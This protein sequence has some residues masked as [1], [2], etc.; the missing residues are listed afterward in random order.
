MDNHDV[1]PV[2]GAADGS[3]PEP[4][5]AG[6]A[7]S[8]CLGRLRRPPWWVWS[9]L[10]VFLGAVLLVQFTEVLPDHAIANI[11]TWVLT[12]VGLV[13]LWAWFLFGSGYRRWV[14]WAT[15]PGVLAVVGVLAVLFRIDHVSGE[16]VPSF[17]L[18][19]SRKAERV[20]ETGSAVA[21]PDVTRVPVDLRTTT[22]FDFP[23]FLGPDRS[24]SARDVKLA[25]DWIARPPQA[26]W[27][28]EIGSGWSGFAVVNGH[29]VTMEQ[30]GPWETVACYSVT[31][32]E[33]EWAHS[34]GARY[35][36]L[37]GGI[38]PRA[39]PT[40]DEG[41]VY[42]LGAMG[43]LMC[44][45]GATGQCRWEKNLLE[46]FGVSPENERAAIP[47]GR[48]NSPLVAGDLVIVPTGG[49]KDGGKVSLV[50]YD[51][52]RGAL[53]W[54]GGDRQISYSSPTLAR[55]GGVEQVLIV[56]EASAS[57]HDV[58]TGRV[59]WEQPW[60]ARSNANPNVSQAVP[61]PP[62]R[63]LLSKDTAEA[64]C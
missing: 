19:F 8:V 33:L 44:L 17:A 60:E 48:S 25:R 18:R 11:A 61:V 1:P 46:E 52:R 5:P 29:A 37:E 38:G 56:N 54:R 20:T 62:N 2:P 26:L 34:T 6:G 43:Q 13:T 64:P 24:V 32:G 10:G 27:R 53:A 40:I 49:P 41:L 14:R 55:L 35:E 63:V 28:H 36:K 21:R 15:V 57:G 9:V 31:T 23:Q 39:T 16:L 3:V 7:G 12:F 50:A 59:L 47:W 51:K 30:R 4:P 58:K 42:A 45:D 22:E